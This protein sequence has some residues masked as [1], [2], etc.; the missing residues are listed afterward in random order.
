MHIA[1]AAT[2]GRIQH[3]HVLENRRQLGTQRHRQISTPQPL[4]EHVKQTL[5]GNGRTATIHQPQLARTP[6]SY[7]RQGPPVQT[8]SKA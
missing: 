6:T 3:E 1:S 8:T 7:S 4:A 5:L 2:H